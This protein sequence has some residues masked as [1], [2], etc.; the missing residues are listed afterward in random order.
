MSDI[1]IEELIPHRGR[2]KF[3]DKIIH[4][5][6][7]QATSL[8]VVS[9]QWPFFNGT[10]VHPLIL[11]EIIA[12]TAGLCNGF[13]RIQARGRNSSQEGFIVGIKKSHFYI[14]FIPVGTEIITCSENKYK[15]G[16]FREIHGMSKI[17][18]ETVGETVLQ[19]FQ[20][21]SA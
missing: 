21:E 8:S 9:S 13:E 20:P 2:M 15:Y 6:F 10:G 3:I 18:S 12:Q 16:N 14:D 1:S 4:I 11:V 7:D 17:G 19:V 5:E